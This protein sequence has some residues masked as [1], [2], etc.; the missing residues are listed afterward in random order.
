MEHS[1]E[2]SLQLLEKEW[3]ERVLALDLVEELEFLMAAGPDRPL[4]DY[5]RG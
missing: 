4:F 3:R 1:Q 5:S 2:E